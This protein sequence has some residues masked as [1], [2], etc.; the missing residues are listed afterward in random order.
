MWT[1]F[2]VWCLSKTYEVWSLSAPHKHFPSSA[3]EDPWLI[4]VT[5]FPSELPWLWDFCL[6]CSSF[7]CRW[8]M[9]DF[10]KACQGQVTKHGSLV[11]QRAETSCEWT[12]LKTVA[13]LTLE[14]RAS[15]GCLSIHNINECLFTTVSTVLA[16]YQE[17][18]SQ[19]AIFFFFHWPVEMFVM[20]VCCW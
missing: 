17:A 9:L 8:M 6:L 5:S 20:D 4:S 1:F 15:L 3:Y 18:N 19:D 13:V 7:C 11:I 2:I 12:G 16:A 14:N 10:T